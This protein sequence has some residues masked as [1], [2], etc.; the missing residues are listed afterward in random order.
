MEPQDQAQ[1][2]EL[3]KA[4]GLNPANMSDEQKQTS[5]ADILYTLNI[6]VGERVID[7]L[8]EDQLKEFDELTKDENADNE[9]AL[10]EWMK[11][12]VPSYNQL[13]EDEIQKM[14]AQHDDIMSGIT[15]DDDADR[16]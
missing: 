9:Q 4:M 6:R 5:L 10:A 14:K 7:S 11:N 3:L 1:I 8:S 16:Q 12:N 2:D 13:I 15:G